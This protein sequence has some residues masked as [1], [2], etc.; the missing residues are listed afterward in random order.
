MKKMM[1]LAAAVAV[2]ASPAFASDDLIAP[3]VVCKQGALGGK[4]WDRNRNVAPLSSGEYFANTE[5]A[6][7]VRLMQVSASDCSQ[8]RGHIP[9]TRNWALIERFEACRAKAVR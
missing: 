6:E 5:S 9:P 2:L 1:F 7:A 3:N 4:C 8:F